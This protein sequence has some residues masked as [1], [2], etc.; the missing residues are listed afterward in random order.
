MLKETILKGIADNP[1][2]L[3]ELK[4]LLLDE[5]TLDGIE[6]YRA[7]NEGLGQVVRANIT[8]KEGIE[9]AFNKILEYKTLEPKLEP[10]HPGR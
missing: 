7:S 3:E 1:A 8:A 10:K 5:F 2:L 6:I 4:K 9:R